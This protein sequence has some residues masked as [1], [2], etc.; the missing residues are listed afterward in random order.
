MRKC[1]VFVL[2]ALLIA[3][4]AFGEW[5]KEYHVGVSGWNRG[6]A[7][8]AEDDFATQRS[9]GDKYMMWFHNAPSA[10][11]CADTVWECP[12]H[13]GETIT[14]ASNWGMGIDG[15]DNVY[16]INQDW[17]GTDGSSILV[18]DYDCNEVDRLETDINPSGSEYGAAL[19][20]DG[21]GYVYISWYISAPDIRIYPPMPWYNLP[22]PHNAAPVATVDPGAYV[23]EGVCVNQAG[24]VLYATNRSAPGSNGWCK[25]YTAPGPTGPWTQDLLFAGDGTLD[26]DG[27][28]SGVDLD[29][30]YSPNGRIF[31]IHRAAAPSN[32][33]VVADALTGAVIE[34]IDYHTLTEGYYSPYDVEFEPVGGDL[35]VADR[36]WWRTSKFH[37]EIT[38]VTMT[39]FE[40]VSAVEQVELTWRVASEVDNWG[41]N[42]YR[43]GEK[44]AFVEGRGNSD[45]P[46][47]YTW[48][49]KDVTA[50]VTYTYRI[51]DV[52]L[53]GI[54]TMHDLTATA[55]PKPAASDQVPTDYVLYQN[56]PNPFNADTHIR[57]NLAEAGHTTLKIYNTTGQLVRTLVDDHRD[58]R[59]H[60]VRWD[61][62]NDYG[63]MVASGVYFYRL[64]S[65]T[66]AETKKM[67]FLR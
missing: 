49:D 66:F 54:E 63:E 58:A 33:I 15:D 56:Y 23:C 13:A 48:I 47:T 65:G 9:S 29:E 31:V 61:G 18:W 2:F 37:E 67:S 19:D 27:Y 51:G 59:T 30:T 38:A 24:T 40:A 8:K 28:V 35:Y 6:V 60:E 10:Y 20:V 16:L 64:A 26:I 34:T 57:F 53:E 36:D 7:V 44:I 22:D 21:N 42:L 50:G 46:L 25:R 11:D 32:Y 17:T 4:T 3:G 52:N 1:F 43:D 5:T 41:Y 14:I 45:S 12:Y 55:T 62:R 39:S